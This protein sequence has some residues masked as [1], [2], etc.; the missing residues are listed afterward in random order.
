MGKHDITGLMR[1]V[2]ADES[3]W[4]KLAKRIVPSPAQRLLDAF[5]D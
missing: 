1:V 3:I 2:G 4:N 5:M